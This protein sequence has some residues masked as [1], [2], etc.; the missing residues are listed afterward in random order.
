VADAVSQ[1]MDK[2]GGRTDSAHTAMTVCLE[3]AQEKLDT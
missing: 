3:R 2:V 1:L